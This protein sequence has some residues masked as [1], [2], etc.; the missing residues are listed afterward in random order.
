VNEVTEQ[1]G[2]VLGVRLRSS[3]TGFV[4]LL[5]IDEFPPHRGDTDF[6]LFIGLLWEPG[7]GNRTSA[8]SP[9]GTTR[10]GSGAPN[11]TPSG[12]RYMSITPRASSPSIRIRASP[13]IMGMF[14]RHDPSPRS[15]APP[16]KNSV[17]HSGWDSA[18]IRSALTCAGAASMVT[19]TVC[20]IRRMIP[21]TR[22]V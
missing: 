1:M 13:P 22:S 2:Q 16:E 15:S 11:G 5:E 7:E 20:V 9:L 14:T 17:P 21:N 19:E 6:P 8:P 3:S 18:F 4:T 10:I 12:A